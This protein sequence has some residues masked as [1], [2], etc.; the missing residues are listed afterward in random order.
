MRNFEPSSR[1]DSHYRSK[2]SNSA[3]VSE[4]VGLWEKRKLGRLAPRNIVSRLNILV[5]QKKNVA[6]LI[7][8]NC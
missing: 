8:V 7:N 2:T 3:R 1:R 5:E 6:A 4:L